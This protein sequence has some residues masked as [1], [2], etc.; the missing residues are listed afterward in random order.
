METEFYTKIE[1]SGGSN[2][3]YSFSV[4]EGTLPSGVFLNSTSGEISGDLPV[5]EDDTIF[6]FVLKV[7]DSIGNE[8]YSEYAIKVNDTVL[9]LVWKTPEGTLVDA[10]AGYSFAKLLEAGLE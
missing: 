1:V 5:V 8:A 9:D 4:F 10:P 2:D 7:S 6:T 3:E